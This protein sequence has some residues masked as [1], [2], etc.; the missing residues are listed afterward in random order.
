MTGIPFI[1]GNNVYL[2]ALMRSD[3]DGYYPGWLND[4]EVCSGNMHHVYPYSV[5]DSIKYIEGANNNEHRFVQAIIRNSDD[6]HIGN[7]ALDNINYINSTAEFTILIGDKNCW[8]KGYAKEAS[9]LICK[10]GFFTLNLNRIYCGTLETNI[11]MIKLAE[12]L[13]MVEEGRRRQA[14]FKGGR[15]VDVIEYGVLRNEYML[16]F[17]LQ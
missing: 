9:K 11:A 10:H 5:E 13:S 17:N 12:Y 16:R 1:K 3:A 14:V 6:S 15:Y 2:R 8:G 7:I 4:D